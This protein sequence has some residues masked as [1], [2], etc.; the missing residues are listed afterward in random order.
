VSKAL[1]PHEISGGSGAI[2]VLQLQLL[3]RLKVL[4]TGGAGYVGGHTCKTRASAGCAS[5]VLDKW[6]PVV[7][8][9]IAARLR[10]LLAN[11]Q[12]GQT[13]LRWLRDKSDLQ[14]IAQ[15]AWWWQQKCSHHKRQFEPTRLGARF[16]KPNPVLA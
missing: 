11:P 7:V 8:A 1:A 4:V 3:M 2:P 15:T 12:R 5:V 14:I 10:A 16:A 6:G 13:L 9:D